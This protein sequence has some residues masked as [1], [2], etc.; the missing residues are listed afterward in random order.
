MKESK[1][2]NKLINLYGIV[3][4]TRLYEERRSNKAQTLE[5]FIRCYG[6]EEGTK[7]YNNYKIKLKRRFTL[8]GWIERHGE[9]EGTK[10][11]NEWKNKTSGTLENFIRRHG[12]EEGTKR[13]NEFRKRCNIKNETYMKNKFGD[14]RYAEMLNAFN[15][16]QF[17]TQIDYWLTKT[18]GDYNL[19]TELLSDRQTTSTLNAF[20]KRH[21]IIEGTK[22]Y[23]ETNTKKLM[24]FVGRS[25]F[26]ICFLKKLYDKI[27]MKFAE[28]Y[29][30][31]QQYFFS[32]D[33]KARKSFKRNCFYVDFYIRDINLVVEVYGDMWHMNPTRYTETDY[34]VMLKQSAKDVWKFD[35]KRQQYIENKYNVE[36]IVVWENDIRNDCDKQL[37]ELEK[38]INERT[39]KVTR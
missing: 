35:M 4:G 30:N 29:F 10:R 15:N 36:I 38:T 19:A 8:E 5:N 23:D 7:R 14:D 18:N 11:Y 24:N 12:E 9:E 27:K 22:R 39:N 3:D 32:L 26:E 2:L 37:S 21:G 6:E 1:E 16:R 17:N 31:E 34:N 20:I 33:K 25:E 13:Y 28:I